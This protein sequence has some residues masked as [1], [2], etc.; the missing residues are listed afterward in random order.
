MEKF[1]E[2]KNIN[3]T[4]NRDKDNAF[5]ALHEVSLNVD[6]GEFVVI[7]GP[8]GSGKSSLMNVIAGLEMPDSG[9]VNIDGY[10]LLDM[11]EK[12]IVD[13]HCRKMGMI[14]QAYNLIPTL[15]VLD[16]VALPQMLNDKGKK[17]RE[18]KAMK[19]LERF[20]V[21]K[22]WKKIPTELSGGQQQR[23]G[24]ARSIINDPEIVLADEPIGNLDT[25]SANNVME[26]LGDLNKKEG[27]TI[28]LVS[29]N[30]ENIIWGSHIV[31]MKDGK[32][33]KEEIKEPHKT[34]EIES[35][36]EVNKSAF[37]KIKDKFEGL[38]EEQIGS[39]INPLKA[40]MLV[41]SFLIPYEKKQMDV[42]EKSIEMYLLK[43]INTDQLL[44]N[45]DK[46]ME[47]GGAELDYRSAKNLSE[48]V[49][50]IIFSAEKFTREDDVN[51]KVVV[52]IDYL[53]D[54]LDL[55][56]RDDRRFGNFIRLLKSKLLDR[57]DHERFKNLLDSSA[58]KDGVNLDRRVAKKVVKEI[59]LFFIVSYGMKIEDNQAENTGGNSN[60]NQ[61]PFIN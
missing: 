45:L 51:K 52:L 42:M 46:N 5:Q 35:S 48:E 33:V 39:M 17:E 41:E 15:N 25:Q 10:D 36:E 59:D 27:K 29:H 54:K 4:Y 1:I 44:R 30:P 11:D 56:I 31:Y 12:G 57:I 13:F 43:N 20:G 55:E 58:H 40:K 28:I 38:S 8:S 47:A 24:I 61:N 32:I 50:K 22:Q 7:F 60:L 6:K 26:I 18:E 37:N 16:N 34:T 9:T 19:N 2:A 14:F 49:N 3:L 53:I 21:E 23:I